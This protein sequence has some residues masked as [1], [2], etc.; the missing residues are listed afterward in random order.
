MI[1]KCNGGYSLNGHICDNACQ[2]ITNL[3]KENKD[4]S[5][6]L[7][8]SL[9][10]SLSWYCY[11][12]LNFKDLVK[13][14]YNKYH[15]KDFYKI[16]KTAYKNLT[17][18]YTIFKESFEDYDVSIFVNMTTHF[19]N[20]IKYSINEISRTS[21]FIQI[22]LLIMDV[23]EKN[24]IDM[25]LLLQ[26]TFYICYKELTNFVN[27]RNYDH[28][29][30]K[31]NYEKLQPFL[32]KFYNSKSFKANN[33]SFIYSLVFDTYDN[34]MKLVSSPDVKIT[35]NMA[36][37]Y[38][39][40]LVPNSSINYL[41]HKDTKDIENT[42]NLF[43]DNDP[44]LNNINFNNIIE[45]CRKYEIKHYYTKNNTIANLE[46]IIN[47][48]VEKN[49]Q[50]KLDDFLIILK[51]KIKIDNPHKCGIDISNE[52]IS[53]TCYS[54]S[55][56]PYNLKFDYTLQLLRSECDKTGNLKRIREICKKVKPDIICL[57]NACKYKNNYNTIVFLC[58]KNNLDININC[59]AL[60]LQANSTTG[61]ISYIIDEYFKDKK[62]QELE[63][64]EDKK[65]DKKQE[66]NN[67]SDL[68]DNKEK[69]VMPKKNT[70]EDTLP[71][72]KVK[73]IAESVKDAEPVKN[74]E[75]PSDTK[76][77]TKKIVKRVVKKIK[78]EEQNTDQNTVE[79]TEE[80]TEEK[81]KKVIKRIIRKVVKKK[82]SDAESDNNSVNSV[83]SVETV[84]QIKPIET[85]E[86]EKPKKVIKK[87]KLIPDEEI[88][89]KIQT[90]IN[91]LDVDNYVIPDNYNYR[92]KYK[93]KNILKKIIKE[94]ET[95]HL[96]A[97]KYILDYL[98]NN[99]QLKNDIEIDNIKFKFSNLDKFISMYAFEI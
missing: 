68:K 31:Q 62:K 11:Q 13:L 6:E 9:H 92:T 63:I 86:T 12:R 84:E 41:E 90:N 74:T 37:E 17:M 16:F 43:L 48:I 30:L 23:Y 29:I 7:L 2:T 15:D 38:I 44:C 34:A 71:K 18:N 51:A 10:S 40:I 64:K 88:P 33:Q 50:I 79:K 59:L 93:I 57:E 58:E 22:V 5:D 66:N 27:D 70:T 75:E 49:Y 94:A 21:E 95:T 3:L 4:V 98:K 80:N 8:V 83:K 82:S 96:E 91:T 35:K 69:E 25:N 53:T 55:F 56:N 78:T 72:K 19:L 61:Y 26:T 42:L 54:I 77:I 67:T 46:K 97:R 28:N 89:E 39:N 99:N 1:K 65:V 76:I 24:N 52:K 87:K 85:I 60:T 32:N 14:Y 73:K 81:P 36:G 45:L 47:M 20:N